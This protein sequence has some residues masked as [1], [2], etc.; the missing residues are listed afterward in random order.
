MPTAC[1]LIKRTNLKIVKEAESLFLNLT[2]AAEFLGLARRSFYYIKDAD[3][4]P[5]PK[6]IFGKTAYYLR[7]DLVNWAKKLPYDV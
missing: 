6:R 1:R 2:Q 5:K 4:F 3:G 7:E